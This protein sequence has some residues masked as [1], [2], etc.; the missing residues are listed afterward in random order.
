MKMTTRGCNSLRIGNSVIR[1][2][3]NRTEH[4]LFGRF[5]VGRV[6]DTI[7]VLNSIK[8]YETQMFF[9]DFDSTDLNTIENQLS[10]E[11]LSDFLIFKSIHEGEP[12]RYLVISP[13]H[14]DKR[15]I[16]L[17]LA[18]LCGLIDPKFVAVYMRDGINAIRLIPKQIGNHQTRKI[19][20][21]KSCKMNRK[22]K[23]VYGLIEILIENFPRQDLVASLIGFDLDETKSSD[24]TLREY[25]TIRW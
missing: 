20:F 25:E 16:R 10:L 9:A 5:M 13:F 4:A 7:G 3:M 23:A 18:D 8:G 17:T 14:Y 2:K 1:I 6:A 21:V 19:E 11:P 12:D 15:T 24:I 22:R